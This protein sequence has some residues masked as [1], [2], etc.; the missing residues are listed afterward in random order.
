MKKAAMEADRANSPNK[1]NDNNNP[2]SFN[3]AQTNP[4]IFP[5]YKN[6]NE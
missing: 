6:L 5:Y 3:S 1:F 2:T 4:M